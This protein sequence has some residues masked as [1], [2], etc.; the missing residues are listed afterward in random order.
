M[1]PQFFSKM[2]QRVVHSKMLGLRMRTWAMFH[3]PFIGQSCLEAPSLSR[4]CLPDCHWAARSSP[5]WYG[6]PLL[7]SRVPTLRFPQPLGSSCVIILP[8]SMWYDLA[9]R[10]GAQHSISHMA[11]CG[12]LKKVKLQVWLSRQAGSH[13]TP[14]HVLH[15]SHKPI[16]TKLFAFLQSIPWGMPK[17]YTS[18]FLNMLRWIFINRLKKETASLTWHDRQ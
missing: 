11:S 16:R 8:I 1:Y 4:S 2:Q 10:G 7:W 18:N 13:S 5:F 9:R 6:C 14:F 15:I 3:V 12:P 17:P